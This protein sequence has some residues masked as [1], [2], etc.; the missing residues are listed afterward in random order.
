MINIKKKADCCGCTA[1]ASVCPHGA[2]TM[3]EDKEGFLYPIVN[4]KYCIDCGLCNSVCPINN[5][6]NVSMPLINYGIKALRL[7]NRSLLE[8]SSS[9]GAFIAVASM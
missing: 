2:I 1:C 7:K 9:G 5:R 3:K 8:R 6:K 4:T